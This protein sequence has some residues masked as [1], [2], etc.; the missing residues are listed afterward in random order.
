MLI[1]ELSSLVKLATDDH[2]ENLTIGVYK[3]PTSRKGSDA[4]EVSQK[5]RLSGELTTL[6]HIGHMHG[7]AVPVRIF[8]ADAQPFLTEG[9]KPAENALSFLEFVNLWKS[10]IDKMLTHVGS[11]RGQVG[12]FKPLLPEGTYDDKMLV[13]FL[14][15]LKKL[16]DM[17]NNFT[18]E[19]AKEAT[20]L[21]VTLEAHEETISAQ[22]EQI[23]AQR[24]E[25]RNQRVKINE[26]RVKIFDLKKE[27]DEAQQKLDKAN[28]ER[29]A[30]KAKMDE[31]VEKYTAALDENLKLA[32]TL[33]DTSK[34]LEQEQKANEN[35]KKLLGEYKKEVKTLD[36]EAL[37]LYDRLESTQ[38]RL[39]FEKQERESL[40]NEHDARLSA[41]TDLEQR[42]QKTSDKAK[43]NHAKLLRLRRK[44]KEFSDAP[45]IIPVVVATSESAANAE[46]IAAPVP[47][48]ID[49]SVAA[50]NAAE[51]SNVVSAEAAAVDETFVTPTIVVDPAAG[52]EGVAALQ[53]EYKAAQLEHVAIKSEARSV[54]DALANMLAEI[55]EAPVVTDTA[56]P[57]SENIVVPASPSNVPEPADIEP[58][59]TPYVIPSTG[60][61]LPVEPEI[62]PRPVAPSTIVVRIGTVVSVDEENVL[63]KMVS[64][65]NAD[66]T[67]DYIYNNPPSNEW[68]VDA[69][70]QAARDANQTALKVLYEL[71]FNIDT[72]DSHGNTAIHKAAVKLENPVDAL[73]LLAREGATLTLRNRRGDHV[74]SLA[75]ENAFLKVLFF[76]KE[77][78][79]DK[80]IV[81]KMV[82]SLRGMD[83]FLESEDF[84]KGEKDE[85]ASI[86]DNASAT[87]Q[88][89]E[90]AIFD[91]AHKISTLRSGG[92]KSAE[93]VAVEAQKFQIMFAMAEHHLT[94][95][96]DMVARLDAKVAASAE[97]TE[98]DM[99]DLK[100]QLDGIKRIFDYFDTSK[101]WGTDV[102]SE[103]V[104]AL[105]GDLVKKLSDL[106]DLVLDETLVQLIGK[107]ASGAVSAAASGMTDVTGASAAGSFVAQILV[108]MANEVYKRYM[109]VQAERQYDRISQVLS[110][111]ERE[112]DF[113]L[114]C[115]AAAE[116]VAEDFSPQILELSG[117][118]ARQLAVYFAEVIFDKLKTP[119]VLESEGV[120]NAMV[121][122]LRKPK[123]LTRG[124]IRKEPNKILETSTDKTK[125]AS[126][127]VIHA[128]MGVG[129]EDG[130]H[131]TVLGVLFRSPIVC[132]GI[133]YVA[134][135]RKLKDLKKLSVGGEPLND[136]DLIYNKYGE[137]RVVTADERDHFVN[138]HGY[139]RE[140]SFIQDYKNVLVSREAKPFDVL[141][142][143]YPKKGSG[144]L[145]SNS[146]SSLASS[147]S[148]PSSTPPAPA[149]GSAGPA[150][151]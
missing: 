19:T 33:T 128:M 111:P 24:Q 96:K 133:V 150:A 3:I 94:D 135:D 17:L 81:E 86:A 131:W 38:G 23:I 46:T 57:D 123:H 87:S 95:L 8:L 73:S 47:L 70:F 90:Q 127:P 107:V 105:S 9:Y 43:K 6:K 25:I 147:G 35:Y 16:S 67:W 79:A 36:E 120:Q 20:E 55:G 92:A 61:V 117:K 26:Q 53:A 102:K 56:A 119:A 64:A 30:A 112:R 114:I 77:W 108:T 148:S 28:Q 42:L 125:A 91:C 75:S 83:Y 93:V 48:I 27:R 62:V 37:E 82:K 104:A 80:D 44:I 142:K 10:I 5:S 89:Q 59:V 122:A 29:E 124:I 12:F 109:R 140:D 121:A 50:A 101:K 32:A 146:G 138:E 151:N 129:V 51:T 78:I 106:K 141:E 39:V 134:P 49:T 11:S 143:K 116:R 100:E 45:G 72:R 74:L 110:E 144:S 4:Q 68:I 97:R 88:V 15:A 65:G 60:F 103:F 137:P 71:G 54:D 85:L 139:V 13:D 136:S 76:L 99:A 145:A 22:G 115:V 63:Y 1:K 14:N 69:Y 132:E 98:K 40:Q 149:A 130:D 58:E 66:A 52:V 21:R 118:G 18:V 84:S 31:A 113:K 7:F 34:K 41:L 126:S 2:L